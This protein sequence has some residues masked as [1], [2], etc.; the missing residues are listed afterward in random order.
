MESLCESASLPGDLAEVEFDRQPDINIFGE[1]IGVSTTGSD[2][3]D[4]VTGNGLSA[5]RSPVSRLFP[6]GST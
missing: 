1:V 3:S 2:D 6:K 5:V 4:G